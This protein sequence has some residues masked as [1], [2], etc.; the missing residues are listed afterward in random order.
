MSGVNSG[1]LAAGTFNTI[2]NAVINPASVFKTRKILITGAASAAKISGGLTAG[3]LVRVFSSE[4]VGSLCGTGTQIH[5]LA[6]S[7]FATSN[8]VET[9]I[10]PLDEASGGAASTGQIV[11]AATSAK[12]GTISLYINGQ[13]VPVS[14]ATGATATQIGAAVVAAV[15]KLS[16]LPVSAVNT[17]GT[18][19]FTAKSKG[20]YGNLI[21]LAK[22]LNGESLPSGVTA[23][24]TD[25]ASGSGVTDIAPTLTAL[26]SGDNRNEKGFTSFVH[27]EGLNSTTLDLIADYVGRGNTAIGCFDAING[28]FFRSIVGDV[29]N[30]LATLI[31]TTDGRKDDRANGVL[32]VPNSPNHPMEFAALAM[33]IMEA[34]NAVNASASYIDLPLPG[35]LPGDTPW[36]AEYDNRDSAVKNG[37]SPTFIDNGTVLLQNVVTF[38]RPD[39][40]P[41]ENNAYRSM[42]NISILQNIDYRNRSRFKAD[43][44]KNATIVKDVSRISNPTVKAK[45]KDI[46]AV[47]DEVLSLGDSYVKDG[48]IYSIDSVVAGLAKTDSVTLRAGGTGFDYKMEVVLSGEGG[49]LN[50]LVL[51]DINFGG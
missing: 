11:F 34:Q 33:G 22:N 26:G 24:I 2:Q 21:T 12:S 38:Y 51:V 3:S 42:R 50:N 44:W 32:S 46:R 31:T 45:A 41:V 29:A 7:T 43:K 14:I 10:C 28:R 18:V 27:G 6:L 13:L 23:T 25:M 8:G 19:A 35:V 9:W 1:S 36:S 30:D 47:K 40:V 17:T 48:M 20:A 49:I 37:I 15:T 16:S 4:Q 5:R 39:T